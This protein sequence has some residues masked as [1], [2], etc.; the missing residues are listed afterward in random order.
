MPSW[1]E[2]VKKAEYVGI[3]PELVKRVSQFLDL[4]NPHKLLHYNDFGILLCWA[5]YGRDGMVAASKHML[6]DYISEA[7]KRE[8]KAWKKQ[9]GLK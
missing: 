1:K 2:H 4:Q 3:D 5:L 9:M 8:F 7:Y 6:D